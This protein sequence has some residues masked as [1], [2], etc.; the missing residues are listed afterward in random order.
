MSTTLAKKIAEHGTIDP[1]L[2]L[3]PKNLNP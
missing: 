3:L 1:W 2:H